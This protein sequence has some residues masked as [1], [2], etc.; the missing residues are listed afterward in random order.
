M[1]KTIHQCR[2]RLFLC[3]KMKTIQQ[4]RTRL[5]LCGKMLE[6]YLKSLNKPTLLIFVSRFIFRF[7]SYYIHC[8]VESFLGYN[9]LI[10]SLK[11][12]FV[13]RLTSRKCFLDYE[14]SKITFSFILA[15]L[16]NYYLQH[17]MD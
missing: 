7:P 11:K 12:F 17:F 5:I 3:G 10:G 4:C 9:I 1:L 6:Q 2:T 16:F 15:L 8:S 13:D 14:Y